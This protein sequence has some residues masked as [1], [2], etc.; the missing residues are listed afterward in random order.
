MLTPLHPSLPHLHPK[1]RQ[2]VDGLVTPHPDPLGTALQKQLCRRD[3][4][5]TQDSTI[6]TATSTTI[7]VRDVCQHSRNSM[8]ALFCQG[9][10]AEEA[11]EQDCKKEPS[12]AGQTTDQRPATTH[13]TTAHLVHHPDVGSAGRV[14]C[15]ITRDKSSTACVHRRCV[16]GKT[17]QAAH[18]HWPKHAARA[19][20]NPAASPCTQLTCNEDGDVAP[21][22]VGPALPCPSPCSCV[23]GVRSLNCLSQVVVVRVEQATTRQYMTEHNKDTHTSTHASTAFIGHPP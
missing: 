17:R 4:T 7:A 18:V 6:H 3:N 16:T 1:V 5:H 2:P 10:Q 8:L 21:D 19:L 13:T 22:C 15:G 23:C 11:E 9:V 12:T 14:S 20:C